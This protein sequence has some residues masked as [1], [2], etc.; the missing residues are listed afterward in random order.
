MATAPGYRTHPEH[1]IQEARVPAP[2]SV[3]VDDV[4]LAD[5]KEVV[6]VDEEGSPP[7]YYFPRADVRMDLLER[8]PS[9]TRCPFKGSAS[10]FTLDL[11]GKKLP[12]AAWSYEDPYEEHAGLKGRIAF[13]LEKFPELELQMRA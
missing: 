5:S 10:Y 12:D 6:R 2:V 4:V 13:Y 11:F 7:R 1:H 8:T 3:I 9:M